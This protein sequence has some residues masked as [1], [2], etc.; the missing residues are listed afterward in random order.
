M[1]VLIKLLLGSHFLISQCMAKSR[2]STVGNYTTACILGGLIHWADDSTTHHRQ[3][4]VRWSQWKGWGVHIKVIVLETRGWG[5]IPEVPSIVIGALN[6]AGFEAGRTPRAW[7][8]LNESN[9]MYFIGYL[10]HHKQQCESILQAIH[11]KNSVCK[12]S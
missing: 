7:I 3:V 9:N 1:Q 6:L 5:Q 2:L 8:K 11:R 10:Q 12:I 4:D